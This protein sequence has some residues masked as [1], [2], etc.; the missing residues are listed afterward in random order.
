PSRPFFKSNKNSVKF[1][2]KTASQGLFRCFLPLPRPL[3]QPPR[4]A[5]KKRKNPQSAVVN[6][7]GDGILPMSD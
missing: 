7:C 4:H 6:T 3:P 5:T 1:F 2:Y